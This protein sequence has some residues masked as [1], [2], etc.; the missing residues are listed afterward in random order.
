MRAIVDVDGTLV[1]LHTP[2][3]ELLSRLYPEIPNDD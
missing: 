3:M 1:D 2:L